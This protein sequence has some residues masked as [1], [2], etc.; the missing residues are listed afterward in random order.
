[1]SLRTRLTLISAG[2]VIAVV[3]IVTLGAFA[4]TAREVE[5]QADL[6][7]KERAELLTAGPRRG[8]E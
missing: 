7:L 4:A 2:A 8:T 1:M 5:A 6:F 3:I